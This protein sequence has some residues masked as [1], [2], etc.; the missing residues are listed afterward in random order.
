MSKIE[1]QVM[2][3]VLVIHTA[4]ALVSAAAIKFYALA[5][6][7]AAIFS[8]SSVP[9]IVANLEHVGVGGLATFVF[10]AF[11]KTGMLV[12][13]A[14]V[15]GAV[16]LAWIAADLVRRAARPRAVFA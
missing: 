11:I 12:R 13:I 1:Q 7:L 8:L 4:R 3:A 9:H 16:A 2:A 5:A 6:S 10:V 15:V 14:T